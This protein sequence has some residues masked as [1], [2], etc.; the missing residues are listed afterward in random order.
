MIRKAMLTLAGVAALAAASWGA[1][2]DPY[3]GYV[4][5]AGGQ[6]GTTFRVTVA[7]QRLRGAREVYVTGKG[8]SATV[9]GYQGPGG[10]LNQLQQ[11]EL[12]R[13]LLEIRDTKFSGPGG[14][15]RAAARGTKAGKDQ[16]AKPENSQQVD[17]PDLP[18][19]R[20]LDQKTPAQLKIIA[21]KYVNPQK[22]PKPP[23]AELVTLEVTVDPGAAPGD[24]ELR[25]RGATGL[26]NP[27]VFQIGSIPETREPGKYDDDF[28][29]PAVT[30]PPIVLNGQILPGEVDRYPIQLKAGQKLVV[31][32][33]ARKLIPYLADAVPGWFQAVVDIHDPDGKEIAFDDDCG[34]DPDPA[35][36]FTVPRD[37]QYTLEIRDSIYRGRE[38]FVYRV[39]VADQSLASTFFPMGCRGGVPIAGARTDHEALAK[40]AREHFGGALPTSSERE[41]NETGQTAVQV[42]LPRVISGAIS[43]PGDKDVFAFDGR[44]GDQIV[45]EVFAR[46]MGSPLDSLVRLIDTTGKVV[47]S[48]DDCPDKECGLL[49]NQSDSCL[50]AKLPA[51]GRYF[52]QVTDAERHG[53]PDYD[54][55]LRISP[56]QPDFALRVTPSSL[57]VPAGRAVTATVYVLRKDGWDGDID[58]SLANAPSGLKL[59]GARIPKGRDHVRMTI[60]VPRGRAGEPTAIQFQGRAQIA[61]K[62]VTRTAVPADNMMQAFAYQHLVPAD[63]TMLTVT[64]GGLISP[65]LD[66]AGSDRLVIPAGGSAKVSFSTN[67]LMPGAKLRLQLSDPPPGV[68]LGRVEMG[69]RRVTLTINADDKHVGYADNLIVEALAEMNAKGKQGPQAQKQS[70]SAGVLPA[71]PFEI[72]KR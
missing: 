13:R 54:Y 7:G 32:A 55:F 25:V 22:R 27:V 49:T 46:R 60:Q 69:P 59:S 29:H 1:G 61:G 5:P 72:V 57:N 18:D 33:Q 6:Q 14:K 11:E 53:G 9:V 43:K 20:N 24:R 63:R 47:A 48:N 21:D 23:I 42:T 26:S 66:M 56:P 52:V 45:A 10:P 58:I 51:T 2:Y 67:S 38:D 4:Y 44:A 31:A 16:A 64:A 35:L 65:S 70:V 36:T 3:I 15:A 34:F 41:P 28:G 12:K 30:K 71:I 37:G 68:T 62:T 40:M 39:D 19:L 8:V 17:L 50:S